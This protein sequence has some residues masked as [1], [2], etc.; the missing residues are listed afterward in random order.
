VSTKAVIIEPEAQAASAAPQRIGYL[1]SRYPAVS[2]TFFLQEILGLRCLG[3]ELQ[4]AS[5]NLPDRA[6]DAMPAAEAEESRSVYYVKGTPVAEIAATLARVMLTRPGVV[7]RGLKFAV[8]LQRFDLFRTG[9]ALLY[10]AEALLVGE[11]MQRK[12]IRHL[13][14]HFCGP[15]AT[16]GMIAGAAWHVPFS[17]TAHGPDEFFNQDDEFLATKMATASFVVCISEYCRSQLM[18][19]LRPEQWGKLRVVRLG[20]QAGLTRGA[21]LTP[22]E[23]HGELEI[24]CVGRLVAAKGQRVLLEAFGGLRAEGLKLRL[25]YVGDGPDRESLEAFAL[26]NGL[27]GTITFEGALN[28]DRVLALVNLADIFVLPSFAEGIPVALMEAMAL[29]VPCVST[30]VAGIPELIR[31]EQDGLLVP[32]GSVEELAQAIGD[33]AKNEAL[34][35]RFARSARE[36]VRTRYNLGRNLG[37]LRA[38]FAECIAIEVTHGE[39]EWSAAPR[40]VRS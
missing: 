25:R 20:V 12:G 3:M 34:R 26:A 7:W 38:T 9:Y 17:I 10:L 1:L 5:I 6:L 32:A 15:V 29:G 21:R 2:H 4:V 8:G 16:V 22:L 36:H 40:L 28:H 35:D 33:L 14:V 30:F 39:V 23:T 37:T 19:I 24:L 13:H 18:R 11:W 31:H 27:S